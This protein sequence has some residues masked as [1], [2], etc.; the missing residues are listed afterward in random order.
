LTRRADPPPD[1]VMTTRSSLSAVAAL[2]LAL[3]LAPPGGAAAAAPAA[4][5]HPLF[6][7]Q[8]TGGKGTV[9]LLGSLHA[10]KA[11]FYPLP[12]P[13]EEDFAKSAVLVEEIDLGRQDPVRLRRMVLEKGLYPPGDRLD[14]HIS[15]ET[16]LALRKY[17]R[18][19]GQNPDV[20]AHMKPWLVAVLV[21]G[22]II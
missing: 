18:R 19:T 2:A 5:S 11:D 8:V 21:G 9:F 6:L 3:L 1:P 12:R 22:S 7:W 4:P 13:I 10:A 15:A 17:L 16:R 20:F 14:D